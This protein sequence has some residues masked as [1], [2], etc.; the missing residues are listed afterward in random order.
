MS[1]QVSGA[2]VQKRSGLLTLPSEQGADEVTRVI[3][4]PSVTLWRDT[5][6]ERLGDRYLVKDMLFDA[7]GCS[8]SQA[9]TILG[10]PEIPLGDIQVYRH[11]AG[12]VVLY[13]IA[14]PR[15]LG[16]SDT[17]AIEPLMERLVDAL[18][19]LVDRSGGAGYSDRSR[20]DD[21]SAP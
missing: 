19:G 2:G 17:Q 3:V 18:S 15:H 4:G 10:T 6:Q 14:A 8:C 20:G 16:G 12:A 5:L 7:G 21:D 1:Q 13:G 11:R 9:V